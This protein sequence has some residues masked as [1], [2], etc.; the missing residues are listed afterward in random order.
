MRKRAVSL[1]PCGPRR[2]PR[3]LGEASSFGASGS[4]GRRIGGDRRLRR[5]G[6]FLGGTNSRGLQGRLGTAPSRP[7]RGGMDEGSSGGLYRPRCGGLNGRSRTGR[8]NW[9]K[10]GGSETYSWQ[11]AACIQ[12]RINMRNHAFQHRPET[13]H[14]LVRR[15]PQPLPTLSSLLSNDPGVQRTQHHTRR[16]L[17]TDIMTLRRRVS[18]LLLRQQQTYVRRYGA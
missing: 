18:A 14:P 7:L 2:L 5:S 16:R 17:H 10:L 1:P 9:T 8:G 4:K 13:I 11:L 12:N 15:I 6:P 3:P